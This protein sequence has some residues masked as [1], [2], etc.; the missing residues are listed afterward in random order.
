MVFLWLHGV[1]PFSC[2]IMVILYWVVD[3]CERVYGVAD[4]GL[5]IGFVCR[6]IVLTKMDRIF[7]FT[8]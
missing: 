7:R 1:S 6:W 5:A 2:F 8:G 3:G 4:N